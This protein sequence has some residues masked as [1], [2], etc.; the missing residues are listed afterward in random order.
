MGVTRG[1]ALLPEVGSCGKPR[2]FGAGAASSSS[3]VVA[4]CAST[5]GEKRR[6]ACWLEGVA[7]GAGAQEQHGEVL[8][9]QH[10]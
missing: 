4:D 10:G 2:R 5:V 1:K 3:K 8:D 6:F 7:A 9:A